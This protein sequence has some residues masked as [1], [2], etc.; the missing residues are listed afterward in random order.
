MLIRDFVSDVTRDIPPVVYF[1]EQS[2]EKLETE[3]SEYIITGGWPANHP[4][5]RRVPDGIHEQYVRLLTGIAAELDRAGGPDLPNSWISGFYGSGKS[6]FAKL[7]G[8]ALDGVAL[9]DGTS[10]AEAW[11]ERDTS[12]NAAQLRDAWRV[13][14]Q[15]VDPLVVVFD[16][17]AVARDNE[18]VHA[19]AVRQ[20]QRK[21]G[22]CST[23]SLVADFE[24]DLEI[25]GDWARFER[26]AAEV[27]GVPWSSVKDKALA[28]EDFSHVLSVMYPQRYSDPMSWFTS[29]SGTHT[30]TESPEDAVKAIQDMLKFRRPGA[31]LFLVVDEVSQYVLSQSDRVERLRAFAEQ[32]GARLKGK[33]WLLALGQQKLE[34]E[35]DASFLV[36]T[37]DRFPPKL[38]VHLAPTNIRDVVHRRL[39]QKTS[40]AEAQLR[41]L[42][43]QHRPDL[44]LFAYGCEAPILLGAR[45]W[46]TPRGRR[47]HTKTGRSG[48]QHCRR[49]AQSPRSGRRWARPPV[50]DPGR[51]LL[52]VSPNARSSRIRPGRQR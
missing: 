16:I 25:D 9:P 52:R 42:F 8:F 6:S 26:T 22:Y 47:L 12:P 14:R 2:P 48:F 23:E 27:L 35:A 36:K 51:N 1:H 29:R 15:K 21:L 50:D 44:K 7:L 38:R 10:L 49:L 32:L 45:D 43:H 19:A 13:L 37:K 28:E 34:E 18:H 5:H 4:N 31:T 40:E 11:L 41:A 17:G 3:V 39:L 46:L 30:R 33:A 20:V 24:L